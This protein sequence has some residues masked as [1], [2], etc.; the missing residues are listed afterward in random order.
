[1]EA[2][3][4]TGR[5]VRERAHHSIFFAITSC[6]V[7]LSLLLVV[8]HAYSADAPLNAAPLAVQKGPAPVSDRTAISTTYRV[9]LPIVS[10]PVIRLGRATLPT[11]DMLYPWTPGQGPLWSFDVPLG[12]VVS[13]LSGD[14]W[15]YALQPDDPH[16]AFALHSG[17]SAL[18]RAAAWTSYAE[19]YRPLSAYPIAPSVA[20]IFDN[21]D[22]GILDGPECEGYDCTMQGRVYFG[23]THG[24]VTYFKFKVI[25]ATRDYITFDWIHQTNGSR[26]FTDSVYGA[27]FASVT[28]SNVDF[29]AG[30]AATLR[31]GTSDVY[32][33]AKEGYN[34]QIVDGYSGQSKGQIAGYGRV[35]FEPDGTVGY[36]FDRDDRPPAINIFAAGSGQVTRQIALPQEFTYYTDLPIALWPEG[37]RLYVIGY[38][39]EGSI[40]VVQAIN[41]GDGTVS[42]IYQ[43]D[44][45]PSSLWAVPDRNELYIGHYQRGLIVIDLNSPES[46]STI[47]MGWPKGLAVSPDGNSIYIADALGPPNPY[48]FAGGCLAILDAHTK[49]ISDCINFGGDGYYGY[50]FSFDSDLALSPDGR[51]AY[52]LAFGG[53]HLM[54]F[55][56]RN[57]R[58]S[59]QLPI[60]YSQ[61][62]DGGMHAPNGLVMMPDGR[63]MFLS[64]YPDYQ[65]FMRITWYEDAPQAPRPNS[66]PGKGTVPRGVGA[67]TQ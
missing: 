44:A 42:S 12:Q 28:R 48:G 32:L 29:Y 21:F 2:R 18:T 64:F 10:T 62:F 53:Y 39:S 26:D 60:G 61:I 20:Y 4:L 8:T 1:M 15:Y 5:L 11:S 34:V 52:V 30:Y 6:A 3:E 35:V 63:T 54:Q 51:F 36:V 65:M 55:D 57:K 38:Q 9:Y 25:E 7:F 23:K 40:W 41:L 31:P 67:T 13:G 46:W 49:E 50:N 14:F 56:L 16:G 17:R 27:L 37:N 47:P 59:D 66:R 22:S 43:S 58:V 45:M 33:A 24:K 19:D